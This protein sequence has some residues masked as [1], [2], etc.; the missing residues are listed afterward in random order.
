M[1]TYPYLSEL[2]VNQDPYYR[3]ISVS[4][5]FRAIGQAVLTGAATSN[6]VAG[7]VKGGNELIKNTTAAI[8]KEHRAFELI[9][10]GIEAACEELLKEY[11]LNCTQNAALL[12]ENRMG[13]KVEYINLKITKAFFDAP[14]E[15]SALQELVPVFQHW[16]EGFDMSKSKAERIAQQLPHV[17][18]RTVALEWGKQQSY[19]EPILKAFE[20]P[21]T[22]AWEER[23]CLEAYYEELRG[24]FHQ[25]ALGDELLPLSKIYIEP[26]F[27]VYKKC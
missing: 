10:N 12:L 13:A 1:K 9:L 6:P 19:Y 18:L 22:K 17:F 26:D 3:R 15:L 11:E 20:N 14:Q 2:E 7:V 24:L 8:S 4:G 16:L 5:F 27:L 25:P 21:F 23:Y